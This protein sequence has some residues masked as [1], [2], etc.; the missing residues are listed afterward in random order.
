M[1]KS[2]RHAQELSDWLSGFFSLEVS[3]VENNLTGFPDDLESAGPTVISTG[4]IQTVA[5]WFPALTMDEVRRR[6]R[7]N[8]E[9]EGVEPF[10]EDRL[11]RADRKPQPFRIGNVEL[12]G[13][14]PCRRCVVP[15]RD[16]LT[17]DVALPDFI[18]QFAE[19]RAESLPPWAAREHFDNA[20]PRSPST[21]YNQKIWWDPRK[22]TSHFYRLSTNTRLL[23]LADGLV[24]IGDRVELLS[25]DS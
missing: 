25:A 16:S 13:T 1:R 23:D 6:F 15:T 2:G 17:G 21:E 3:I 7:A 5:Q 19:R 4:T 10:W 20:D 11:F 14:N 18:R 24:R 9:I 8:I 22:V 12:G